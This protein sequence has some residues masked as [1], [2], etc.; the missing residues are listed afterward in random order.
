MLRFLVFGVGGTCAGFTSVG[1]LKCVGGGVVVHLS[2]YG[3]TFLFCQLV[4]Y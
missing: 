4:V 2:V 1:V 3:W